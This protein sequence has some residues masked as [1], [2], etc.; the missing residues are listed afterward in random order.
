[1]VGIT[2]LIQHQ[3][4]PLPHALGVALLLLITSCSGS[5]AA[6]SPRPSSA[7]S[8]PT[9][10]DPLATE[11]SAFVTGLPGLDGT[12]HIV[13]VETLTRELKKR[14]LAAEQLQAIAQQEFSLDEFTSLTDLEVACV[15]KKGATVSGVTVHTDI[16]GIKQPSYTWGIGQ[17]VQDLQQARAAAQKCQEQYTMV[18]GMLYRSAVGPSVDQR[19]AMLI[20]AA[21]TFVKCAILKGE[22]PPFATVTTDEMDAFFRWRTR[23]PQTSAAI[24]CPFQP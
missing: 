1:M 11:A 17:E 6:S 23:L 12:G 24:D 13:D 18:Y 20:S 8:G 3:R 21:N 7:Q 16:Y 10:G 14:G 5:S 22:S 4:R 9:G 15:R 19:N 2:D